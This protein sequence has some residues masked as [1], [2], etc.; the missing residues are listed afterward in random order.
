MPLEL[1][2]RVKGGLERGRLF[3]AMPEYAAKIR[4]KAGFEPF[5]GTLNLEVK[6]EELEKFLKGLEEKKIKGFEKG[7]SVYGSLSLYPVQCLG[8]KAAILRPAKSAHPSKIVEIIAPCK[9]REKFK[10][11]NNDEVRLGELK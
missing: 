8:E 10:L 9:L 11:K 3:L 5:K 1:T 6:V 4:K 2:G 7:K